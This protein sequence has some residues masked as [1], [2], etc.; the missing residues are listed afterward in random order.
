MP[1]SRLQPPALPLI[2]VLGGMGPLATA[3]FLRKLVEL[4]PA[5]TD[6]EH[7][8]VLVRS[9]PQ[10][11]DRSASILGRGPSPLAA[12]RG[13]LRRLEAEGATILAM[14]CN[15]AHHWYDDLAAGCHG[16][17]LHIVDAAAAA[18]ARRGIRSGPVGLLATAGT[19]QAGI[20]G[21]RLQQHGYAAIVPETTQQAALVG[22]GI[23][24]VKAGRG[25]AA[26]PLFAAA[27][28]VLAAR[29]ARAVILG[30]TEI[31]VAMAGEADYL[32]LP[33]ID[34]TAALAAACVDAA[35]AGRSASA[36]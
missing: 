24:L 8:P 2:G 6:Q 33:L 20:Y 14:P 4:T 15:T 12:L 31:P 23:A 16:R 13:H 5:R 34:S 11:P 27:A 28:T 10:I 26:R 22:T 7:L 19:L 25:H 21:R 9:V 35:L 30:C 29:G 1:L 32:G 3:D 36:A 17:F 18:L